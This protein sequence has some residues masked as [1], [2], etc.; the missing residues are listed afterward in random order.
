M[1]VYYMP[2]KIITEELK[3]EIINFYLTQPMTYA[4]VQQKYNLSAPTVGKILSGVPKYSKAK[5]KNPN[6]KERFFEIID[7]F[8]YVS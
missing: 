6:L 2:R 8:A 3:Q 1:E 5:I 4:V 7:T